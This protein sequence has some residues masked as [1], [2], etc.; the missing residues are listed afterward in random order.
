MPN[1]TVI[2]LLVNPKNPA[3]DFETSDVQVAARAW[4]EGSCSERAQ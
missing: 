1:A 2:G 4:A 3:S